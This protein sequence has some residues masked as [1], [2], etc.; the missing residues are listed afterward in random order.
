MLDD[1]LIYY[2]ESSQSGLKEREK[3]HIINIC[4][5][6]Q[7]TKNSEK[8]CLERD[9]PVKLSTEEEKQIKIWG[10][11]QRYRSTKV[12]AEFSGGFA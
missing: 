9:T 4:D 6:E 7:T 11:D 10:G 1:W 12:G 5:S 2:P 8:V 3:S